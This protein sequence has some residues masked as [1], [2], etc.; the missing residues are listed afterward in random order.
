MDRWIESLLKTAARYRGVKWILSKERS[1]TRGALDIPGQTN[2]LGGHMP[3][4]DRIAV[5][6]TDSRPT[7]ILSMLFSG[8]KL[9]VRAA[10]EQNCTCLLG[11]VEFLSVVQILSRFGLTP[12]RRNTCLPKSRSTVSAIPM[13]SLEWSS[14]S[15]RTLRF[16][17]QVQRSSSMAV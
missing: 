9:T 13:R 14:L 4:S 10:T 5:R 16:M 17:S 2:N 8:R 3:E 12:R 15:L 11:F 1:R 6:L 7:V